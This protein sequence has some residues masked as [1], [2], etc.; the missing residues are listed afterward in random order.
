[1]KNIKLTGLLTRKKAVRYLIY[2]LLVCVFAVFVIR[3]NQVEKTELVVR[4]GQT[5]EKAK[6]VKILQDNLEEN[7]T[8]VGEQKV[9]VHMLTGVRKGEELDITSSSGYLFGAACKLGMKVI[10]MQ[11]VAGDS[12][13]ASVYTQDRE[14]VIYIFA[15]IYLL[16]LF[17]IG[18][19]QGI[20]GC[21]GLVF[22]FFCVIFVYL[23]LVYLKYS[24]F[25][26]AVFVCFITTLVTM[27]LIGGPT[28][29]TCAATLG[30]LAGV[31]L[32]GIS[33]WCFSKASGI[34]G[35]NVS[36]IETLMTLW[37]TNRIQVGG[38]LFS[39]LL[40]SCLGAVMDVAMS[41]SSAIDEI[42][43]QNS[44][45]TRTE[46]FK[47]GLRVG[48]DMMGT[49]SNTLILAF[50][51]SSVSTLLLDY[52]YDLPYQ[53]IINSNNIGIAIMQ[54]LAGSFGI[55]LSVPF[56]VLICTVLFHKNKQL[57]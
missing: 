43:K 37:N 40:I 10:V 39:G 19:K 5:F 48:R 36:D 21:L 30:T 15:L 54:G 35:Y 18:G 32:A 7:G 45:L 31:V 2:F 47:A 57:D 38:L 46:L 28:R 6:V 29:K 52:A 11:S 50:A 24:P 27:Y 49:D 53:Q 22:T 41:I 33:A 44:S 16:A 56:T 51:G 14:S 17:M 9:R 42:Y 8:R 55:V 3:L 1:M 4:T 26:T 12:T 25:W 34:S 20:K 23:P 13:V